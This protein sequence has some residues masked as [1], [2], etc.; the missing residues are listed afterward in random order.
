VLNGIKE[1]L[2]P[3]AHCLLPGVP[4]DTK[5]EVFGQKDVVVSVRKHGNRPG[6]GVLDRE[7]LMGSQPVA[8]VL[9]IENADTPRF[10][11]GSA[12]CVKGLEVDLDLALTEMDFVAGEGSRNVISKGG[13]RLANSGKVLGVDAGAKSKLG[14]EPVPMGSYSPRVISCQA[15]IRVLRP[16][17]SRLS[18][19]ASEKMKSFPNLPPRQLQALV[20]LTLTV[21]RIVGTRLDAERRGALTE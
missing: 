16:N 17:G 5:G 20:R 3:Y 9:P 14:V 19:A 11:Y 12:P 18:C 1:W 10:G 2:T 8:G 6:I 21:H 13:R 4:E 15:C 7:G